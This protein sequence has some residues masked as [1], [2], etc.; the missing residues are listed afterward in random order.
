MGEA[1]RTIGLLKIKQRI[2][3]ESDAGLPLI[4]GLIV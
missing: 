1:S 3:G 2:R 4:E